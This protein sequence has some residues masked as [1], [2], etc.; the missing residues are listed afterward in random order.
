MRNRDNAQQWMLVKAQLGEGAFEAG[1]GLRAWKE[2]HWLSGLSE[3]G[4]M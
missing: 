4:K 3:N 2:L 1:H